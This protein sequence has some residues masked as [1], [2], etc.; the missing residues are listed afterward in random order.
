MWVGYLLGGP[1][2]PKVWAL[3]PR[4]SLWVEQAHGL[5]GTVGVCWGELN[6]IL[7]HTWS[8]VFVRVRAPNSFPGL[9]SRLMVVSVSVQS[10]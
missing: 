3:A 1:S 5:P 10:M 6:T 8:H 9:Y 4:T 2:L 7:R